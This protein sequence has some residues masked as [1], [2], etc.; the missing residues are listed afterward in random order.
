MEIKAII[1]KIDQLKA[2]A[3]IIGYFEGTD[4]LSGVIAAIDK[5]LDGTI[6][7]LISQKEIKGKLNE[8]TLIHS[9][10]KLPATRVAVVG[11]GK[12]AE[13]TKDKVRNAASSAC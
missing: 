1:G 8:V 6:S 9:L 12:R 11:L 5:T 4:N 2:D 10:N 3:I 7:Q 13:L